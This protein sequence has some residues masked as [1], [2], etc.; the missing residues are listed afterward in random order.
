MMPK[1]FQSV[2]RLHDLPQS[3]FFG[4]WLTITFSIAFQSLLVGNFGSDFATAPDTPGYI[5]LAQELQAFGQGEIS[6]VGDYV[7]TPGYPAIILGVAVLGGGSMRLRFR[8]GTGQTQM[9]SGDV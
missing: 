9:S 7:R 3:F 1:L 5:Q 6:T 2:S 8:Y 4:I